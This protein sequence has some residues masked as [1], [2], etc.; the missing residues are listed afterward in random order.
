MERARRQLARTWADVD[1]LLTPTTP[2]RAIRL[3]TAAPAN[4]ADYTALANVAGVPALA[5][6][7]PVPDQP[8]A[9]SVQ[10]IGPE[11]SEMRL[12]RLAH[13]LAAG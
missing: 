4:Q 7:V 9:A 10:V 13:A 5:I 1:V 12:I 3:G 6:P 2:Q 8:L 11:W